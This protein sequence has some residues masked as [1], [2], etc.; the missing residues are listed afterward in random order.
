ML[1]ISENRSHGVT[2]GMVF[3]TC[4]TEWWSVIGVLVD[5]VFCR[6]TETEHLIVFAEKQSHLIIS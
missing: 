4:Q 5:P 3:P 6:H 1:P 2:G